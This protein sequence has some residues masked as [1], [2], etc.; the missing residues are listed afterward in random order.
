[1]RDSY[2]RLAADVSDSKKIEEQVLRILDDDGA[3]TRNK[4]SKTFKREG[5][6]ENNQTQQKIIEAARAHG[7][8]LERQVESLL[9]AQGYT[10]E[11]GWYFRDLDGAKAERELDVRAVWPREA[12]TP[13]RLE[14]LAECKAPKS[15]W[16]FV[17]DE[18]MNSFTWEQ[19]MIRAPSKKAQLSEPFSQHPFFAGVEW[20]STQC[21]VM[22]ASNGDTEIRGAAEKAVRA[23][24][25]RWRDGESTVRVLPVPIVVT[26][27]DLW[28]VRCDVAQ[29]DISAEK[30]DSVIYMDR[31]EFTYQRRPLPLPAER[32]TTYQESSEVRVLVTNASGLERW[33]RALRQWAHAVGMTDYSWPEN[34]AFT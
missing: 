20:I 33:A 28:A 10:A 23:A 16:V 18:A 32:L 19:L 12:D 7:F 14:L 8:L 4:V 25:S 11:H 3:N 31:R 6:T 17:L 29:G 13:L 34:A 15:A 9:S 1:M 24:W 2:G 21:F 27:T 22:G 5:Q 30:V 26:S